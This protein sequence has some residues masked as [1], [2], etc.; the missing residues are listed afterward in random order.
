MIEITGYVTKIHKSNNFTLK[1]TSDD[2]EVDGSHPEVSKEI[3]IVVYSDVYPV[4]DNKRFEKV[5]AGY[6][7]KRIDKCISISRELKRGDLV[8]CCAFIV[9]ETDNDHD[10]SKI[11]TI[12]NDINRIETYTKY[13][14]LWLDPDPNSFKRLE[15]DTPETLKFRKQNYYTEINREKCEK[16]TDNYYN[17]YREKWWI[18]KNPKVISPILRWIQVRT[19]ASNLWKRIMGKDNLTKTLIIVT[20]ISVFFNI[21]LSIATIILTILLINKPSP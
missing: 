1:I 6:E 12:D 15:V 5:E 11:Y 19:T 4:D 20:I 3:Q 9:I 14:P 13:S 7:K 8:E 2:V 16:I 21:V 18:N 17:K 10:N